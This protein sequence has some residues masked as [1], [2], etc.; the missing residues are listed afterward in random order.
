MATS[1]RRDLAVAD[2]GEDAHAKRRI[3]GQ[4]LLRVDA[5]FAPARAQRPIHAI[6]VAPRH[7]FG[8]VGN[9]VGLIPDGQTLAIGENRARRQIGMHPDRD[10]EP[11][12]DR[13]GIVIP[14]HDAVGGDAVGQAGVPPVSGY[15]VTQQRTRSVA[16]AFGGDVALLLTVDIE[17]RRREPI[18]IPHRRQHV[19]DLDDRTSA[20]RRKERTRP[21]DACGERLHIGVVGGV[22]AD[23]QQTVEGEAG[24]ARG[25]G[26]DG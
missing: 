7:H 14:P 10:I 19:V 3:D 2:V 17:H 1:Q 25:I 16:Q 26:G 9:L 15:G 20:R 24:I 12:V 22:E 11:A 8:R 4:H 18:I 5:V 21:G 23:V 13:I 6:I